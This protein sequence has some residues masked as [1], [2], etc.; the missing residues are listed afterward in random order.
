M[1][2]PFL[3]SLF[4]FAIGTLFLALI[5]IFQGVPLLITSDVSARTPWWAYL[6]GLLGMLGLT[7]NI[8]LF[9]ILGSVQTVILPILGQL[10]MSILIDH[11]GLFHTLLR[12][13]SFNHFLGFISLIVGAL[14]IVF[15]P[16]YLQQKRQLM[17]E[18]KEHAPSNFSGN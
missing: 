12:Q 7:A 5:A 9:P 1:Q 6:G 11:F 13:L 16:S 8:L 4:S 15:L 10:L 14:L 17:K 3:A 18:T 2:S